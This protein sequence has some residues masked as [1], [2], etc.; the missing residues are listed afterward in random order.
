MKGYFN[1]PLMK[2]TRK[3][4][5]R[6]FSIEASVIV[7]KDNFVSQFKYYKFDYNY[8]WKLNL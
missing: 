4:V 3:D 7:M 8:D 6:C 5:R 1:D 2:V